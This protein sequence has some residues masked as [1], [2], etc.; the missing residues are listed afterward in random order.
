MRKINWKNVSELVGI[1]VSF[2]LSIICVVAA[3]KSN[4]PLNYLLSSACLNFIWLGL[5]YDVIEKLRG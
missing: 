2:V 4:I 3:T 5:G 1:V